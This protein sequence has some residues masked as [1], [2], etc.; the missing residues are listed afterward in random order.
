MVYRFKLLLENND[1]F[2]REIV[3]QSNQTFIDFHLSI[4]NCTTLKIEDSAAFY[5][6]ND[7]WLKESKITTEPINNQESNEDEEPRF[8]NRKRKRIEE[9]AI[10]T[11]LLKDFIH[12]PHQ[13][14]IYESNLEYPIT[15]YV[16]LVKIT[17]EDPL[18]KYPSCINRL[19]EI[20]VLKVKTPI[21]LKEFNTKSSPENE[22]IMA[23]S[24]LTHK[25]SKLDEIDDVPDDFMD[26]ELEALI[27]SNLTNMNF[28]DDMLDD[29]KREDGEDLD[30]DDE[31]LEDDEFA[32]NYGD[33]DPFET[34]DRE[35]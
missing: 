16:E 5:I 22:I 10:E 24:G 11:A 27:N 9:F 1:E 23:M 28:N 14:M 6:C 20:P 15:L 3:I 25:L 26:D 7:N 35:W 12:D 29:I 2:V 21:E 4:I 13:K 34:N 18:V 17:K 33:E 8:A 19:G 32:P 31:F 30:D